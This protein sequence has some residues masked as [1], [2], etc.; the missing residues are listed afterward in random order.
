MKALCLGWCLAALLVISGCASTG[1]GSSYTI[2]AGFFSYYKEAQN[3]AAEVKSVLGNS[4]VE[5]DIIHYQAVYR[6][7]SGTYSTPQA[8]NSDIAKLKKSGIDSKAVPK[9]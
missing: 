8:A 1:Q 3:R 5:T 9:L 6:V 2:Q 7:Y 4:R